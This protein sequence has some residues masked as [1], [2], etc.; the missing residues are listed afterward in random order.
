MVLGGARPR[1]RFVER[2]GPTGSLRA[3]CRGGHVPGSERRLCDL[4]SLAGSGRGSEHRVCGESPLPCRGLQGPGDL[5]GRGMRRA[6]ALGAG[7]HRRRPEQ[8]AVSVEPPDVEGDECVFHPEGGRSLLAEHEEHPVETVWNG[9]DL[10]QAPRSLLRGLGDRDGQRG[11][12]YGDLV[13]FE[14][15]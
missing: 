4:A 12:L 8:P 2:P 13:D 10:T 7:L 14:T 1:H 5:T 9:L 6:R 11:V 3:R 15:L